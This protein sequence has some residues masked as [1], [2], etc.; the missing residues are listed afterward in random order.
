MLFADRLI[1]QIFLKKSHIVVGLDPVYDLLPDI[2]KT[3]KKHITLKVICNAILDFN[4]DIIDCIYDIVPAVKPQIAFY[5]KYG[6]EGIKTFLKTVKYAQDKGLIVIEDA[7]RND[8]G[9]TAAAYSDG[10]IGR[11][12]LNDASLEVFNVDAITINPYL[13]SDG[14]MPFIKDIKKYNKGIFILVKT[15]NPSSK[16]LQDIIV[17]NHGRQSKFYEIVAQMVSEWGMDNIGNFGYSS[18]GAVV[19]ATFPKDAKILR[20]LMPK[21]Y[22]LVPGYGAQ[23]G[24]ASDIVHCFNKDGLGAI[25]AAS[26]SIIYA[27]KNNREYFNK[28]YQIRI[29]EAALQMNSEINDSLY[30]FGILNCG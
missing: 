18:V 17:L 22:F 7:K 24:M 12:T 30:K 10:H 14:V 23:G 20:K 13:G 1:G 21:S 16:E 25:V 15:S 29:R 28:N 11:V 4:Y 8:I 2:L 3:N 9:T 5:E 19:G 6:V 27:F 26:R